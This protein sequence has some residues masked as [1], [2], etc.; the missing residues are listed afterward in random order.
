MIV[1]RSA[2]ADRPSKRRHYTGCGETDRQNAAGFDVHEFIEASNALDSDAL[3]KELEDEFER[4]LCSHHM[5]GDPS[6]FAI[7]V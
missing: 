4:A 3:A 7:K 1:E 6:G 5:T 2:M